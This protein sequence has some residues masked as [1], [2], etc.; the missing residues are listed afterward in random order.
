MYDIYSFL[1]IT[2]APR[3]EITCRPGDTNNCINKDICPNGF[4]CIR[5]NN[6]ETCCIPT[7]YKSNI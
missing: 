5:E 3:R 7:A 4:S 1:K 6:T 2:G